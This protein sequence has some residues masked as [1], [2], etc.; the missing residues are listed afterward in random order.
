VTDKT[1]DANSASQMQ[2]ASTR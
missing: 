1:N 2:V